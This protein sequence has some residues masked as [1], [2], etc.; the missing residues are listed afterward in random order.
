MSGKILTFA[1]CGSKTYTLTY[2]KPDG[3]IG[4]LTKAKGF[5]IKSENDKINSVAM[6]NLVEN[7]NFDQEICS[8][9]DI[10][11]KRDLNNM[12]LYLTRG[13][14]KLCITSRH[15]RYFLRDHESVPLG[16]RKPDL[17]NMTPTCSF[18]IK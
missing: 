16:T 11:I 6:I 8:N 10:N 17:G 15:K 18:R 5:T 4:K 14:K 3:T 1:A 12:R 13:H 9:D 7:V 2:L